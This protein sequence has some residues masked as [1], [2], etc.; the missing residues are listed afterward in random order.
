MSACAAADAAAAVAACR[1]EVAQLLASAALGSNDVTGAHRIASAM[2]CVQTSCDIVD[3]GTSSENVQAIIDPQES[4]PMLESAAHAF[5]V[6]IPPHL[7]PSYYP[8]PALMPAADD[9]DLLAACSMCVPGWLRQ[10]PQAPLRLRERPCARADRRCIE[11]VVDGAFAACLEFLAQPPQDGAAASSS[12]ARCWAASRVAIG[13][14]HAAMPLGASEPP[15]LLVYAEVSARAGAVLVGLGGLPPAR[16]LRPLVA[17]LCS[18]H[19]LFGSACVFSGDVFPPDAM[20]AEQLLPPVARTELLQPC[21]PA[22]FYARH[23]RSPEE[24]YVDAAVARDAKA[25]G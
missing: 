21:H 7:R 2:H 23:G 3:Q 17:W 25:A 6:G 15:R 1:H 24:A 19:N 10:R 4:A 18:L 8:T 12:A 20:G 14:S 11:L 5:H 9:A 22:C 13:P 16:R